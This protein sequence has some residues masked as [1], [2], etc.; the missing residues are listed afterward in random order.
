MVGDFFL[1]EKLA[2]TETIAEFDD[3]VKMNRVRL[4][5]GRVVEFAR[6]LFSQRA[7]VDGAVGRDVEMHFITF[8][9]IVVLLA[10]LDLPR[11]DAPVV[12]E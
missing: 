7:V 9:R 2:H 12:V 11:A 10:Q 8:E 5:L 1:L 6:E 4:E 3:G